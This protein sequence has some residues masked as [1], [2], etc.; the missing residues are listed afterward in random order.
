VEQIKSL[1]NFAG[2]AGGMN[3]I[4]AAISQASL[5]LIWSMVNVQMLMVHLPLHN[6]EMPPNVKLLFEKWI[7]IATLDLIPIDPVTEDV[8]NIDYS[9]DP[10]TEAFELLDYGSFNFFM[11]MG[12]PYLFILLMPL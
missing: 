6:E 9:I 4:I 1:L 7:Q 11:L 12:S 10:L 8:F 5:G 2:G 3:L